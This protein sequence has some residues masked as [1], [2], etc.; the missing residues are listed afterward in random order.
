MG[1]QVSGPEK[2][3][4]AVKTNNIYELQVS[5]FECRKD[6]CDDWTCSCWLG[7]QAPCRS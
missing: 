7:V 4:K 3:Y 6:L 2:V 5:C 1:N